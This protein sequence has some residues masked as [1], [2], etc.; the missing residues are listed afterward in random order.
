ME[1]KEL[2]KK[3]QQEHHDLSEL[4]FNSNSDDEF[5]MTFGMITQINYCLKDLRAS[6]KFFAKGRGMWSI[7]WFLSV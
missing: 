3:W 4:L 6:F 7:T 5:N 2:I 1:I